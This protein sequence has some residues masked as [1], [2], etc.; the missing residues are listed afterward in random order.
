MVC[1][2]AHLRAGV[3]EKQLLADNLDKERTIEAHQATIERLSDEERD[4]QTRL[5]S[6][7][8]YLHCSCRALGFMGR[9]TA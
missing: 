6:T 8:V 2:A 7:L 1:C 4:M 5:Y 9:R 3:H